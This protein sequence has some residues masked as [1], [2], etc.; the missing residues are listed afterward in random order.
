MQEKEPSEQTLS[1]SLVKSLTQRLSALSKLIALLFLCI[2]AIWVLPHHYILQ[3]LSPGANLV[4]VS[5]VVKAAPH[6][7]PLSGA[8]VYSDRELVITD[9]NGAFRI[10]SQRGFSIHVEAPG[11]Q[12]LQ[13]KVK[14]ATPLILLLF[15]EPVPGSV[16]EQ[17]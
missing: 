13:S 4:T 7:T 16:T 5:G 11:Y 14:D 17:P 3:P 10:E 15:P 1:E 2:M 12:P 9:K 6:S 8:V